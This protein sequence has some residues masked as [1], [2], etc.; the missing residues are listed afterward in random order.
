MELLLEG[1]RATL[2][3]EQEARVLSAPS[4]SLC[5]CCAGT[6]LTGIPA[7]GRGTGGPFPAPSAPQAL[8]H[9]SPC[10]CHR[11]HTRPNSWHCKSHRKSFQLYS[12]P[13]LTFSLADCR[14]IHSFFFFPPFLFF[15]TKTS[16]VPRAAAPLGGFQPWPEPRS[17]PGAGRPPLAR[18]QREAFWDSHSRLQPLSRRPW[19]GRATAAPLGADG[20]A[21]RSGQPASSSSA[22][23]PS[24]RSPAS[25]TAKPG[26]N[27][28][29]PRKVRG[30][31]K[32]PCKEDLRGL[33][34]LP[35]SPLVWAFNS[36]LVKLHRK[37]LKTSKASCSPRLHGNDCAALL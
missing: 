13:F 5:L 24:P 12:Q 1:I 29:L 27:R 8:F 28:R 34:G 37:H 31:R 35:F 36:A 22:S 25:R 23:S 9:S 17:P 2:H 26:K 6:S 15:L 16:S 18:A 32:F 7:E 11:W 14:Y 20:T 21:W 10:C 19:E 4:C 3:S 30:S 33:G